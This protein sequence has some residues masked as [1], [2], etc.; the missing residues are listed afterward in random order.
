MN[1][2]ALI[3]PPALTR[4]RSLKTLVE[5]RTVYSLNHCE[6]NLFETYQASA[7]VPLQFDDLVVTSMLRGKKVMHLFDDPEFE[8]LPGETVVIPSKVEMKID[9]PEATTDNPTQCLAL[10]IDQEKIGQTLQL[11]N[12]R[13]PKEG[14]QR[15]WQLDYQNY[16]FY[17]NVE[18]AATI[19]KLIKEC[20]SQ[21]LTKDI[22]ADLTLQELLIRIIQ[23]QTVKAIDQGVLPDTTNPIAPVLEFI[24][25]NLRENMSM[26]SLSEKACM[27]TTSFYRFF[28]R[29]LGM[30]PL[31][32]VLKEKIKC[33][34]QLLKNPTIQVN[35]VCFMSGF[36]DCNY[37]IRLFKKYEGITPKQYQLLHVN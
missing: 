30:S 26:K 24:R 8:Y 31:E 16:F 17:N 32:F 23:T 12:E 2:R 22:L 33:A 29:E 25:M 4:E 13:Y 11:L 19:S 10:A 21:S 14:Q 37:F 36:E 20:T 28:K 7:L 35:E 3:R 15:F 27:S 5:N 1:Q 34:K 9:F 18:L 6:L